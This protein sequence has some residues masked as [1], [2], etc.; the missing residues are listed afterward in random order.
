MSIAWPN[1]PRLSEACPIIPGSV[2]V[3]CGEEGTGKDYFEACKEIS[4]LLQDKFS[5]TQ[6]AVVC[7]AHEDKRR[8]FPVGLLR[9]AD[10]AV[11]LRHSDGLLGNRSLRIIK[12]WLMPPPKSDT[13]DYNFSPLTVTMEEIGTRAF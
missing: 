5:G 12:N 8:N 6:S 11:M 2:T 10:V 4:V 9:H 13:I 3:I 7:T 1:L